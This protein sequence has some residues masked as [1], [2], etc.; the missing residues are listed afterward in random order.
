M[1]SSEVTIIIILVDALE[2][3]ATET[4]T[5]LN[6]QH[7]GQIEATEIIIIIIM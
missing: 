2:I 4:V 6:V 3:D 7:R 1:Y 5:I